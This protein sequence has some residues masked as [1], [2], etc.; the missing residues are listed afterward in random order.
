MNTILWCLDLCEGDGILI[1]NQTYGAIQMAAQEVCRASKAK[2]LVLN[3]MFPTSDMTG[4]V[5]YQPSEIV[6]HYERV[7]QENPSIKIA[8]VDAIT[9]V[10]AVKLPFKRITKVCHKH[11]VLVLVDGAHAP[12]QIPLDLE[13]L[14]A[15]FFVGRL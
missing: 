14:G 2:L 10:S 15:D 6:Q 4:S 11:N 1:T 13:R 3:I 5:N 8:I 9:S 12:G 7:L